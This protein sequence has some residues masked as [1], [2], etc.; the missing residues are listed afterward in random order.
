[1]VKETFAAHKTKDM[2]NLSKAAAFCR[3]MK[4]KEE[5]YDHCCKMITDL[6]PVLSLNKQISLISGLILILLAARLAVYYCRF[7]L[8]LHFDIVLL[9]LESL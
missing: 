1:M 5:E 9:I 3:G 6:E 2:G 8:C 4:E 7:Q